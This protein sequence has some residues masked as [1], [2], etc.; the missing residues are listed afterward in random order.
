MSDKNNTPV[1]TRPA[2]E[3]PQI[4]ELQWQAAAIASAF[5]SV[6]IGVSGSLWVLG[7]LPAETLAPATMAARG[8]TLTSIGAFLAAIVTFCTVAWRAKVAERQATVQERQLASTER[9]AVSVDENNLALLLQKGAELIA[10]EDE[11]KV[12]AGIA[13]LGAAALAENERFATEALNLLAKYIER[14][15]T[16]DQ[17]HHLF[18]ATADI[19]SQSAA[20]NRHKN[21]VITFECAPSANVNWAFIDGVNRIKYINGSFPN[22]TQNKG[23]L[24]KRCFYER[25]IFYNIEYHEYSIVD[26]CIFVD[27]KIGIYFNQMNHCMFRNCDF[28][29]V[30]FKKGIYIS[31][32]VE[33]GIKN[34]GNYYYRK[35]PPIFETNELRTAVMP[36]LTARN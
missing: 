18:N 15:H 2:S 9:Q 14:K 6:V 3:K 7:W 1:G 20:N 11:T 24:N 12:T 34:G 5:F 29:E 17:T 10:D 31:D 13:S 27:S 30:H 19:L 35:T 32:F 8:R 28:S 33:S 23:E 36:L 25:C 26:R 21:V 4:T 22:S 16:I